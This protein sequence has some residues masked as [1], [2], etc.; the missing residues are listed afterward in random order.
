MKN[1]FD[2]STFELCTY[3]E[4]REICKEY[5]NASIKEA[6]Y[7]LNP[8]ATKFL[9]EQNGNPDDYRRFLYLMLSAK[10]L[11]KELKEKNVFTAKNGFR[12]KKDDKYDLFS[13]M[14]PLTQTWIEVEDLMHDITPIPFFDFLQKLC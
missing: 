5:Y 7:I 13:A 12:L 2:T 1:K 3:E 6:C 8:Q 4:F 10:A 11:D 9:E 14:K